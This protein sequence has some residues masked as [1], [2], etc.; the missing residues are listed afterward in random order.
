MPWLS[1]LLI[2]CA[3]VEQHTSASRIVWSH[4]PFRTFTLIVFH[5]VRATIFHLKMMASAFVGEFSQIALHQY[6]M[7]HIENP[8]C[9]ASWYGLIKH[10]EEC[11]FSGEN[12]A[13]SFLKNII[14]PHYIWAP[15]GHLH[16]FSRGNSSS[17]NQTMHAIL[18]LI[19]L[20]LYTVLL[21]PCTYWLQKICLEL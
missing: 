19:P 1:S 14:L 21:H 12:L 17:Y 5:L 9:V 11:A 8:I 4:H 13:S 16:I 3:Y 7:I 10:I 20:C 18:F 6:S 15:K 2:N